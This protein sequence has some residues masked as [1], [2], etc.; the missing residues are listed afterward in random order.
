MVGPH[1]HGQRLHLAPGGGRRFGHLLTLRRELLS[2]SF[3]GLGFD[4]VGLQEIRSVDTI[5]RSSC[6]YLMAAS[7]SR[8]V[9]SAAGV[10]TTRVDGCELWLH[11]RMEAVAQN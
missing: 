8:I 1:R 9:L 11:K 4:V 5:F 6:C 7:A 3:D 10:G 2:R